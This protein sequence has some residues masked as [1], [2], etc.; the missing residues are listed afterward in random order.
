VAVVELHN[1]VGM[2]ENIM[3]WDLI[4]RISPYAFK[5]KEN[6]AGK[7]EGGCY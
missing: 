5:N 4:P 3:R 2:K 6:L 7:T 1:E